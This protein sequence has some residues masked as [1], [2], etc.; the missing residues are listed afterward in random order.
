MLQQQGEN[1]TIHRACI[2]FRFTFDSVQ[3]EQTEAGTSPIC[4]ALHAKHLDFPFLL[5]AVLPSIAA[6]PI[7]SRG[8]FS[9]PTFS[10]RRGSDQLCQNSAPWDLFITEEKWVC[11]GCDSDM[12]QMST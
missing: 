7:S 8:R 6:Q 10:A 3:G 4:A 9:L 12:F 5:L 2:T 1:F 11:W